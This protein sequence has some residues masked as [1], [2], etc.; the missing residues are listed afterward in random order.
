MSVVWHAPLHRKVMR[1]I[2]LELNQQFTLPLTDFDHVWIWAL[3]A[4]TLT[5]IYHIAEMK[6]RRCMHESKLFY[7]KFGVLKSLKWFYMEVTTQWYKKHIKL[8]GFFY[9][10]K[11][12]FILV[13]FTSQGQR[14]EVRVPWRI[15]ILRPGNDFILNC[16][17]SD[18]QY[19]SV[20][21]LNCCSTSV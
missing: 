6:M 20:T 21:S 9:I 13:K 12:S 16:I 11:G 8:H 10:Y 7:L 2:A 17:I 15:H 1:L 5:C 18:G 4:S 14:L 3:V 19:H